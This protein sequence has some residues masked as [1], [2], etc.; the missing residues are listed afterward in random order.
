MARGGRT[1][2]RGRVYYFEFENHTIDRSNSNG[3]MN[4]RFTYY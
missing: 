1:F 4:R 2:N 3:P